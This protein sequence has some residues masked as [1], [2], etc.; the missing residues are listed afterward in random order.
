MKKFC[1]TV[2]NQAWLIILTCLIVN[3]VG[4]GQE[5][6]QA[7]VGERVTTTTGL[8][9]EV[10]E[11]GEGDP[12]K[13]WD[14]VVIR[15]TTKY[16]DGSILFSNWDKGNPLRIHIG[17]RQVIKGLEMGI[18]GMRVGEHR[19]LIVPTL[20]SKR[21]DYPKSI[22]PDSVLYYDIKLLKVINPFEFPLLSG[23]GKVEQ[24]VGYTTIKIDYERP[25]VRGRK[26]FGG[27]LPYGHLWR[28]GAGHCTVIS[29]DRD[30][31]IGGKEVKAGKYSLFT[32]PDKQSWTIILNSDTNLYGDGKYTDAKDI[33][34]FKVPARKTQR[35]YQAFTIDI[36]VVPNNAVVYLSWENTQVEFPVM[37]SAD[38][39][40]E[41]Y[42][43]EQ[44]MTGISQKSDAYA[45]AADYYYF[46]NREF[47][48]ALKL[49][50]KA[51]ARNGE[52]WCYRLKIDILEKLGRGKDG[53]AVAEAGIEYMKKNY[54][55]LGWPESVLN[56]SIWESKERI[57]TLSQKYK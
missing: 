26:I 25:A 13:I 27:L 34:R 7:K 48:K 8:V 3:L 18:M 2:I 20:L 24:L 5:N 47:E 29:F 36:D 55:Q 14:E 35:L 19:K 1:H 16:S 6:N 57:K 10:I 9:F 23:K 17:G 21:N 44:L 41:D 4:H 49:I 54:V 39:N 38:K 31:V 12:V 15:E 42:I 40:V 22:S 30:V 11:A 43:N 32:I 28:T 45:M 50:D 56:E 53:I 51:I 52:P 46:G 33:L 37:T